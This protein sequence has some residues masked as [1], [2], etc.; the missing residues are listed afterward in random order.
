VDVAVVSVDESR[1]HDAVSRAPHGLHPKVTRFSHEMHAN[2][3]IS[4]RGMRGRR[5][6]EAGFVQLDTAEHIGHTP[7][8][9]TDRGRLS[10]CCSSGSLAPLHVYRDWEGVARLDRRSVSLFLVQHGGAGPSCMQ[11]RG[12]QGPGSP[13]DAAGDPGMMPKW[14]GDGEGG[15]NVPFIGQLGGFDTLDALYS[16]GEGNE[17]RDHA[18]VLLLLPHSRGDA[19]RCFFNCACCAPVFVHCGEEMTFICT[20]GLQAE[21]G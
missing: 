8:L 21:A 2:R 14:E 5:L 4:V 15:E 10:L 12:G 17:V 3:R 7:H 20:A 1:R 13:G 9:G 6:R 11:L 18:E 19:L 16:E